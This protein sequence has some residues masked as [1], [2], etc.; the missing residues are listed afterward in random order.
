[1]RQIILIVALISFIPV[2][3]ASAQ[4]R[5]QTEPHD[6]TLT[7]LR[8]KN[9][10]QILEKP[11]V[12][13]PLTFALSMPEQNTQMPLYLMFAGTPESFAWEKS[14]TPDIAAPLH[15]QL[16]QTKTEKAFRISLAAA[17]TGGAAY[18]AYRYLKKFGLK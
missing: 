6:T 11:I 7:L 4:E 13:L 14:S 8:L 3:P 1:M 16:Y 12:I 18:L 2:Y 17:S 15:L 9:P 5:L 10:E